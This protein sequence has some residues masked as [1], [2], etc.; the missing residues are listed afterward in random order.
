MSVE[1]DLK[2]G[3]IRVVEQLD[4]SSVFSIAQNVS[5]QIYRTFPNY[6]FSYDDLLDN[7]SKVSLYMAEIPD[8]LSEASYF[9]KNASIYFRNGMSIKD[10]EKY[11]VHEYIHHLQERKNK[12][13]SL[14]RMGLCEFSGS[15][16]I[17][18][19]L[20]EAAVQIIKRFF[21]WNCNS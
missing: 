2:K 19:A 14:L 17:G 1:N 12:R 18:M 16:I 15:K 20:N 5:T 9:Y 3:G 11:S 21:F 4:S 6:E 10:I 8:G 7:L 13:G